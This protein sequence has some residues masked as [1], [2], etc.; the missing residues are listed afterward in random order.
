MITGTEAEY[1]S[2]AIMQPFVVGNFHWGEGRFTLFTKIIS[3]CVHLS[4][5]GWCLVKYGHP[6]HLINNSELKTDCKL[7][8]TRIDDEH[9]SETQCLM[10]TIFFLLIQDFDKWWWHHDKEIFS[11]LLA[12][13]EENPPIADGFT[14]QRASNEEHWYFLL[15][16]LRPS[17]AYM[18]Q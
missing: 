3:H 17:D 2:D 7:K 4:N 15:N 16:S 18:R 6:H 1:Q 11:A 5:N 10:I 12:H 14:P 9:I 8:L 13:C